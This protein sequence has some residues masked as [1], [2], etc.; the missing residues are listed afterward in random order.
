MLLLG[1]AS[2]ALESA[3]SDDSQIFLVGFSLLR[4]TFRELE[5]TVEQMSR[6]SGA[7]NRSLRKGPGK[8]TEVPERKKSRRA[9]R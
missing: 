5:S 2:A 1:I 4:D 6:D 3:V 9:D 8:N 7:V